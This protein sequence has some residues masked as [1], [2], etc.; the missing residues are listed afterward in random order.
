MNQ[1]SDRK[2]GLGYFAFPPSNSSSAFSLFTNP[3]ETRPRTPT[4][5]EIAEQEERDRSEKL[6]AEY[7][8][9]LLRDAE[10]RK[11]RLAREEAEALHG[12]E[13]WVR[14]GGILRDS[15]GRRDYGRTEA[16]R[17]ELRVREVQSVLTE[18]WESY[19]KRWKEL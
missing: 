14:S 5:D 13:E 17:E 8:A 16:I 9:R 3:S 1:S 4:A 6:S 12:E 11:I 19:E 2:Q 18:R 10:Q 15:S 7:E